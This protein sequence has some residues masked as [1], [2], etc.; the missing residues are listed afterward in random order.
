MDTILAHN[1]SGF[2]LQLDDFNSG[3]GQKALDVLER[4][5]K[6][7]VGGIYHISGQGKI[8][9]IGDLHEQV[10]ILLDVFAHIQE[11]PKLNLDKNKDNKIVL[12]GDIISPTKSIL[13]QTSPLG[14][15]NALPEWLRGDP[16]IRV[17]S[18]LIANYPNQFFIING[19]HEVGLA[20]GS[21]LQNNSRTPYHPLLFQE[22]LSSHHMGAASVINHQHMTKRVM[23]SP[24]LIQIDMSNGQKYMLGHT[25][26]CLEFPDLTEILNT[27]DW[28]SWIRP[29]NNNVLFN[30]F[31]GHGNIDEQT[32]LNMRKQLNSDIFFF[33]HAAPEGMLS[34]YASK[35]LLKTDGYD[36]A[37]GFN[38]GGGCYVDSQTR[39]QHSG[40]I[41]LD[42]D[43][44]NHS[45]IAMSDIQTKH[46]C[47]DLAISAC[48]I[49]AEG[50]WKKQWI[51]I[52]K[53]IC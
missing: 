23:L 3:V 45:V 35:R 43:T 18:W 14:L 46:H 32:T 49:S 29:G 11:N 7:Q 47:T 12:L 20:L 51:N 36:G 37:I 8:I 19:N 22:I 21:L 39:T 48:K 2:T 6:K 31:I 25:P 24:M 1:T 28:M 34:A 9:V 26:G 16:I 27:K 53:V 10:D 17:T 52:L 5:H 15:D 44:Y 40:Y 33:G 50:D 4:R 42:C 41:I 13:T 30:V 38:S